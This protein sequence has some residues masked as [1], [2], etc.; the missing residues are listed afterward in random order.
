VKVSKSRPELGTWH[1]ITKVA[2]KD[3]NY[4]RGTTKWREYECSSQQGMYIGYRFKFEGYTDFD[5][6]MWGGVSRWFVQEKPVE[7]WLFVTD[8]RQNPI[9]VFPFDIKQKGVSDDE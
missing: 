7:V 5:E 9:A 3:K 1:T 4:D 8:V 6:D 2:M